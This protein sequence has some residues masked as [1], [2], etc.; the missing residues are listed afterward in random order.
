MDH[1]VVVRRWV[2]LFRLV[3]ASLPCRSF[4][5]AE[6]SK[7][8]D[9]DYVLRLGVERLM[10]GG[11]GGGKQGPLN[12]VAHPVENSRDRPVAKSPLAD[13]IGI[14]LPPLADVLLPMLEIRLFLAIA[15]LGPLL[16]QQLDV[17]GVIAEESEISA[18]RDRHPLERVFDWFVSGSDGLPQPVHPAR[19]G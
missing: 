5:I 4:S 18:N 7:K 16:N 17:L 1:R 11:E 9:I 19:Y 6:N 8:E 12:E 10:A 3:R 13:Q 15:E 2:S 14:H